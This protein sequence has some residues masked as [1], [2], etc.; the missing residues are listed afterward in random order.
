MEETVLKRSKTV[1]G[2][3]VAVFAIVA[4]VGCQAPAPAPTAAPAKPAAPAPA[5]PAAQAAPAA[6]TP[7]KAPAAAAFPTRPIEF[8]IPYAPGGGSSI[9]AELINKAIVD[10]KLSPQPLNI[11]YKPG[12]NGQIG[13]AYLAGKK[14]DAHAIATATSSFTTGPIMGQ[15]PLKL[16]DFTA[17]AGMALDQNLMVTNPKSPFKSM[18]D[19]IEASKKNPKSVKLAG[20]GSAGSDATV[21]AML[22]Q[23][24]GI[25]FNLIP[26]NS[27]AEVN[28][29]ILG[30]QVDIASSNPNELFPN[31][32]A[33]KL[34]PLVVFADERMSALK[35]VPTMKELGYDV[36]F[37]MVRG[38]LAPA[39]ISA[40]EQKWLVDLFKKVYDTKEWADYVNKNMMTQKFYGGDDYRKY[41]ADER[42]RL[43]EVFKAMGLVKK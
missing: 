38:I 14:G 33:G 10:H 35:D 19:V 23:K 5:Q 26:F 9:T 12:A 4:V 6:A 3:L 7:T 39:G 43:T 29:A 41:L 1:I 24:A 18:K 13:W 27:G 30:G 22:E 8:V 28:A 36:T 16:E 25:K 40:S 17:I 42:S 37:F 20:T 31:I 34:R 21:A 2:S 11:S 32:E 15:S